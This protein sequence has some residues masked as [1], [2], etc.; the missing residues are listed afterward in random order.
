MH[1]NHVGAVRGFVRIGADVELRNQA[2][3]LL[4]GRRVERA[5]DGTGLTQP[6]RDVDRG[7]VAEVV[8]FGFEREAPE[9][10]HRA[11]E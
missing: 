9:R 8:G 10:D 3:C 5:H 1:R 7:R 11:F 6:L 4:P 2:P